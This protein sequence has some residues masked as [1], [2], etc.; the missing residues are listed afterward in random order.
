MDVKKLIEKYHKMHQEYPR[1]EGCGATILSTD[2]PDVEYVKT[3][4]RSELFIH[5]DCV[6][7]VWR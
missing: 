3:K 1:C 6:D 2:A 5:K 4:R 7:E